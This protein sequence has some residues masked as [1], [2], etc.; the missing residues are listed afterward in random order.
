M[1]CLPH[2]LFPLLLGLISLWTLYLVFLGLKE[3]EILFLLFSK[4]THFIPCHKND[5][6]SHV[7]SIFFRGM[8][9]EHLS[10]N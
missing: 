3:A 7:T 4:M 6:A 8:S 1:V 5:D 9:F 10:N 2:S